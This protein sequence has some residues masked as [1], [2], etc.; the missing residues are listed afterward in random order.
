MAENGDPPSAA[1]VLDICFSTQTNY[2]FCLP[3]YHHRFRVPLGM[4]RL[5]ICRDGGTLY[6]WAR[7]R[8]PLV[9]TPTDKCWADDKGPLWIVDVVLAPNVLPRRAIRAM[10][11]DLVKAG[12]A[13]RGERYLFW[14]TGRKRY[15]FAHV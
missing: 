10:N 9:A 8:E 15:G 4:G 11:D 7:P 6:T 2:E 1:D 3:K 13:E 12:I 5:R 14:R